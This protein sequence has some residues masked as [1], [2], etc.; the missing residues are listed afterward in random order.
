MAQPLA[1]LPQD[2]PTVVSLG[3][4]SQAAQRNVPDLESVLGTDDL[5]A[6]FVHLL[7]APSTFHLALATRGLLDLLT[8]A[9]PVDERKR[10]VKISSFKVADLSPRILPEVDFA[11]LKRLDFRLPE[12]G[13]FSRYGINVFRDCFI[14]LSAGLREALLLEELS[15]DL[16]PFYELEA[17]RDGP[18]YERLG[19]NL[20]ECRK[21][22]RLTVRN[23]FAPWGRDSDRTYYS[24]DLLRALVPAIRA[25][26]S[27]LERLCLGFGDVPVGAEEVHYPEARA[28][29]IGALFEAVVSLERLRD[30]DLEMKLGTN[31]VLNDLLAAAGRIARGRQGPLPFSRNLEVFKLNCVGNIEA[32]DAYDPVP[33]IAPLLTMIAESSGLSALMLG[34]PPTHWNGD[35]MRELPRCLMEDKPRMC[36]LHLYFHGHRPQDGKVPDWL[37]AYVQSRKACQINDI[38]VNGL[39]CGA[40]ED[41]HVED[42]LEGYH[43]GEGT[44]CLWYERGTI[45]FEA[46]GRMINWGQGSPEGDIAPYR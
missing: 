18:Y 33:P 44:E 19:R 32:L 34:V 42:A 40:T 21:L 27:T 1:I 7:D 13:T 3:S 29:E 4:Q 35:G 5:L 15:V 22:K 6:E 39:D 26:S 36:A 45:T 9:D 28:A 38:L 8:V 14:A 16:R 31:N 12:D 43:G 41:D 25:R 10:K 37:L 17:T 23:E 46:K 30:L 2:D 20:L 11:L 24:P